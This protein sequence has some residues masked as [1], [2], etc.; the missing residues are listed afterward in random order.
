MR[1]LSPGGILVT[2]SC[3]YN[4]EEERSPRVLGVAACDARR[5]VG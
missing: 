3:S 2:S 1:M 5:S 4:L